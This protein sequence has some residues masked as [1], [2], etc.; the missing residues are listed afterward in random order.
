MHKCLAQFL[1]SDLLGFFI[2]SCS[3]S[4]FRLAVQPRY[5]PSCRLEGWF[6]HRPAFFIEV[7]LAQEHLSLSIMCLLVGMAEEVPLPIELIGG[8]VTCSE[9]LAVGTNE[10]FTATF[11]HWL[12][13]FVNVWPCHLLASSH[14][15]AISA[16]FTS[17]AVIKADKEIVVVVV[18]DNKGCLDSVVASFNCVIALDGVVLN[19]INFCQSDFSSDTP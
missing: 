2:W 7:H 19:V 6:Y 17:A 18:L 3:V 13:L 4:L 12:P 11:L 10:Y 14:Y 16:T 9:K 5:R 15:S 1:Q 8:I